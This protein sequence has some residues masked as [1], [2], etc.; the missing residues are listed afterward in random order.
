MAQAKF[1]KNTKYYD[2][3]VFE[4]NLPTGSTCPMAKTCKVTVDRHTG[5]F[6]NDSDEYKCYAAAPERF[7]AVRDHR[8]ANFDYIKSGN[9]ISELIPK[10][11]KAVRIHA[12]GDFF[13]QKYFDH[14]LTVCQKNS[15]IE[16]WAYMKSI[17]YWVARLDSIPENMILT[18][19]YGG[20]QDE[21]ISIYNLKSVKVFESVED[22]PAGVGIDY[23]DNLARTPNIDFALIDNAKKKRINNF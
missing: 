12:S 6:K 5:K 21:L 13:N 19:S 15:D 1:I 8:W 10:N 3:V 2:G 17:S 9:D 18:A 7:P 16:F 20:T 23:N 22:V 11:C 4:W 14:W